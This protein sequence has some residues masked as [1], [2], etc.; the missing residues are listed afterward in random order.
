M[1]ARRRKSKKPSDTHSEKQPE[2]QYTF[3]IDR[4]L[5][6]YIIANALREKGIKVEI[7]DD[8]FDANEKDASWLREVGEKGWI[9][10]TKDKWIRYRAPEWMIVEQHSVPVFTFG[11]AGLKGQEMASIFIKAYPK[12]KKFLMKTKPPFIATITRSGN[13]SLIRPPFAK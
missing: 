12:I 3:F 8:H 10:L 2:K 11:R 5:G 9:V 4:C 6:K 1:T 13:L 7:C